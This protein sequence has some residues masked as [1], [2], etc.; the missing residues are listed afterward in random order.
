M[1]AHRRFYVA[2]VTCGLTVEDSDQL[3]N[4]TLVLSMGLALPLCVCVNL[5]L[6]HTV[7]VSVQLIF[8]VHQWVLASK[9]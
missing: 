6:I 1:A 9:G 5:L 8:N 3:R 2:S 7:S 4:P